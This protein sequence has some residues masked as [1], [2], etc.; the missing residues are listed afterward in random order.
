MVNCFLNLA[1]LVLQCLIFLSHVWK[2]LAGIADIEITNDFFLRNDSTEEIC[3]FP[4]FG[5]FFYLELNS[6]CWLDLTRVPIGSN[7][8]N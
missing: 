4:F 7:K 6:V 5:S 3:P 1:H 8:G 2:L